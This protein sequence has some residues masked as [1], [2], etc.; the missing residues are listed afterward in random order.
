MNF[1]AACTAILGAV[2]TI[3][4]GSVTEEL[5]KFILPFAAGGFIYLA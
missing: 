3:L 1:V 5:I 4:L 2:I